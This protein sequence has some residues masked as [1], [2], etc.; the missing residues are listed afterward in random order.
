[1]IKRNNIDRRYINSDSV[2]ENSRYVFL[3]GDIISFSRLLKVEKNHDY[4]KNIKK[5]FPHCLWGR[6]IRYFRKVSQIF[7]M[8]RTESHFY[9]FPI[10]F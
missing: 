5:S 3:N 7:F 9:H 4:P 6:E 8:L 2:E 10:V 1:M